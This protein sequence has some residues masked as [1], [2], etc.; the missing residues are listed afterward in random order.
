MSRYGE[1]RLDKAWQESEPLY[2][3][4]GLTWEA[5]E[6]FDDQVSPRPGTSGMSRA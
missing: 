4:T 1:E 6:V 5:E 2:D 3:D